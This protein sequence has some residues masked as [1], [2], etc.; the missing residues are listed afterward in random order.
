M[1]PGSVA[2]I[3]VGLSFTGEVVPVGHLALRNGR[4]YF[5]YNAAF[6]ESGPEISPFRCPLRPGVQTFD[7]HFFDG[8]PGVFYDSLPDGWGRLL[9]DRQMRSEGRTPAKLS[10][11]DRLAHV[12][13]GGMGALVYSP[14]SAD[15]KGLLWDLSL[16][17]VAI[18]T[19]RIL[20]GED[21][22]MLRDLIA[23]NGSSAGAR[24]KIMLGLSG[25]GSEIVYG[26]DAEGEGFE[27]WMAKFPNTSDGPDAG[28]IE[29]VYALMATEAGVEIPQ[30]RLLPSKSG[31]GYFATK[32]FDRR[33]RER[34]HCHSVCGLLHSDFR[35]PSLDYRDLVALA[36]RLA[37]DV[38]QGEKM[39]RLAVFNVLA[40]NRD[41]H[42]KNFSFLMDSAGQWTL[43]LAYDLTFSFG[44]GGEQSTTVMG[45]GKNPGGE[46]LIR[47]GGEVG[48]SRTTVDAVIEQTVLALRRWRELAEGHGVAP[49][50]IDLIQS[51]LTALAGG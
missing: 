31:P 51:K 40:H 28:A 45:E 14:K 15:D 1:P 41:D 13:D 43:S 11:L 8:L 10:A 48:L 26:K 18:S 23:L 6:I 3:E 5:E 39:F 25:D 44:P 21:H 7:P 47:L 36:A 29:Y 24:P 4:I 2:H 20:Q 34:F 33:G 16:E 46:D 12:G 37:M 32:R 17:S 9:L 42:S 27:I 19:Q 22:D 49:Q 50:N 35:T 30:V 38:G